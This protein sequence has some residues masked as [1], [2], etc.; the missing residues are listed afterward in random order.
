MSMKKIIYSLLLLGILGCDKPEKIPSYIYIKPFTLTT[1]P[2][3]EG[4]NTQKITEVWLYADD[5][6]LGA[7]KLPAEVPILK[8][9]NVTLTAFAGVR[10]NGSIDAPNLYFHYLPYTIAKNLIPAKTD[11]IYPTTTYAKGLQ[12]RLLEDFEGS[13]SSINNDVDNDKKTNAKVT[14]IGAKYGKSC[15]LLKVDKDHPIMSVTTDMPFENLKANNRTYMEMDYNGDIP[16]LVEFYGVTNSGVQFIDAATFKD[17]NEWNKAYI[18]FS[19]LITSSYS[20][21]SI[22]FT[23]ALPLDAN[24]KFTKDNGEVRLDNIKLIHP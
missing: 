24:N 15:L 1:D 19:K 16:I 22:N 17:K 18:N 3:K 11:T 8:E 6:L 10:D 21:Y 2:L 14:T 7:F 13:V 9:G 20:R 12:F 5:V 23:A 4:L